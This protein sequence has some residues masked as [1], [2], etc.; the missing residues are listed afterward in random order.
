MEHSKLFSRVDD[1]MSYFENGF[2]TVAEGISFS[3]RQ[4]IREI[5]YYGLSKYM[6]GQNDEFGRR[7]PFRNVGNFAVDLE[8]RAVNIDRKNIV[9]TE[10]D[11]DWVFALVL[12]K[13]LQ[14]AMID[15]NYGRVIDDYQLKKAAFGNVL[16][17]T[18]EKDK[19]FFQDT[20]QWNNMS[21]DQYDIGGG[22]KV[23]KSYPSVLDL[24]KMRK[25][26]NYDNNI[27]EFIA[28]A[29]KYDN[30]GQYSDTQNAQTGID[31][32]RLEILDVEGEFSVEDVYEDEDGKE[33]D[34]KLYNCIIGVVSDKKYLLYVKQIEKSRF[35]FDSRRVVEGRSWAMGVWEEVTEPQIWINQ[36]TIGEKEAMD[37]AGKVVVRTSKK[38]LPNA[39]VMRNGELIEMGNEEKFETIQLTPASI[40][41]YAPMISNWLS[42]L[43]R[44]QSAY[45]GIT[46]ENPTAGTPFSSLVLQSAQASSI[47]NKRRDQ[48]GYFITS[49]LLPRLIEW[50][51]KR[52]SKS[53]KL[54]ASY[55]Y[56]ELQ[57]L[58]KA[59][60][61]AKLPSMIFDNIDVLISGEKGLEEIQQESITKM[62]EGG[63]NREL[64]IPAGYLTP[65]KI[66]KK[67]YFNITGELTDDQ[68][69]VNLLMSV[70][71][72]LPPG[73][74]GRIE[75]IS[76]LMNLG[77]TSPASYNLGIPAEAGT[78]PKQTATA[79]MLQAAL[80]QGQQ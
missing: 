65:E 6:T 52:I 16:V 61:D 45:A 54:Y 12:N 24:E 56:T 48:D 41:K 76:E 57:R 71:Q 32:G 42:D 9:A 67:T 8:W 2:V 62:K 36:A 22:M 74:P 38:G 69:K 72:T 43:Q 73:D 25:V 35:D 77:G 75:I 20:V 13:E 26:W 34:I 51:C 27:D 55:S 64:F 47:F 7:L 14:Q 60:A 23:E 28:Q 46:G 4:Q 30:S 3:T 50:M 1:F 80:P 44:N 58:D 11:G 39:L 17:K 21:V 31:D 63:N 29:K 49:K 79:Q 40:N 66:N 18:T 37:I 53:H 59:I 19:E 78:A 10:K 33:G 68:K 15:T 70:L 5:I